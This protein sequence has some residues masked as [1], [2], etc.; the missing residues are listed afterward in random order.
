M[1][2]ATRAEGGMC[3]AGAGWSGWRRAVRGRVG[4]SRSHGRSTGGLA[5]DV[6]LA[7]LI[8]RVAVDVAVCAVVEV[9]VVQP[10]FLSLRRRQLY[11]VHPLHAIAT[12]T[13]VAR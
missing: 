11:S 10:P 5:T 1:L 7:R 13:E 8:L 2:A 4:G 9:V 3:D 12:K 6:L